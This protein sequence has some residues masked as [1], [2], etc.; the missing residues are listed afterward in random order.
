MLTTLI[1]V[2]VA[3]LVVGAIGAGIGALLLHNW[4]AAVQRGGGFKV[5]QVPAADLDE[6]LRTEATFAVTAQREFPYPP[7]KVW[8]ALQLDGTFSWIPFVKG[9]RYRDTYLR[10]G[11]LRT[12]D[13]LLFGVEEKVIVQAPDRRLAVSGTRISLPVL[14]RSFAEDY[15]LR[16]TPDGTL[17]TWTIAFRPR[18]FTFLPLRW[19]APF[20]RPFARWGIRGLAD[21]I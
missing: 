4:T 16:E 8:D 9:I 15:Q 10:E 21:R 11:A 17:L 7:H 5:Q 13:G 12:F 3:L 14:V 1:I 19:G 20:V 2:V 18:F 6:F